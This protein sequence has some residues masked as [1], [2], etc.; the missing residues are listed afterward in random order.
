[1]S[2]KIDCKSVFSLELIE[3]D[4]LGF[5]AKS[6]DTLRKDIHLGFLSDK[7]TIRKIER[8]E[9][10]GFLSETGS[11]PYRNMEGKNIKT[12]GLTL[13]GFFASIVKTNLRDNYLIKKYL[14]HVKDDEIKQSLLNYIESDIRLFFLTNKVMG[15]TIERMKHIELWIDDY[16]NLEKFLKKDSIGVTRSKEIMNNAEKVILSKIIPFENKLEYLLIAN[17]DCW[18]DVLDLFSKEKSTRKIINELE[19]KNKMTTDKEFLDIGKEQF[20]DE[21]KNKKIMYGL[22]KGWKDFKK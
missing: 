6:G 18:Y 20:S 16:D 19:K 13:K 9:N 22:W 8:L 21:A 15:I 1:M 10:N 17:Y 14:K 5:V 4:I 12:F 11:E 7:Q 3:F 2:I